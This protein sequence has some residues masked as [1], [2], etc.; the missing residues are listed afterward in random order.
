MNLKWFARRKVFTKYWKIVLKLCHHA[1]IWPVFRTVIL[2]QHTG[3][4]CRCSCRW[5]ETLS[6][7]CCHQRALCSSTRWHK[8]G[9]PRWNDICRG[10]P[11]NSEKSQTLNR[12]RKT[13]FTA[14][15]H[16]KT[17]A[18]EGWVE[19]SLNHQ[20]TH[21]ACKGIEE[22]DYDEYSC[23]LCKNIKRKWLALVHNCSLCLKFL[24]VTL[25][26]SNECILVFNIL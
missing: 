5:G 12:Q 9:E 3:Y 6:L 8:Y 15:W 19:C 24:V 14:R 7:S 17:T 18:Y 16:F 22:E 13:A 21:D 4:S 10:K 23:D 2:K 1:K 11:K 26:N 20:S 25:S